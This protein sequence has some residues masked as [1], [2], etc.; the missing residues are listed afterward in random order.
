MLQGVN[1]NELLYIGLSSSVELPTGSSPVE[2]SLNLQISDLGGSGER[3]EGEDG[4][5][6][7]GCGSGGGCGG[8]GGGG[9]GGGGGGGGGDGVI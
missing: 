1:W 3:D 2:K 7:G 8:G 4:D 9:D 5:G 6:G